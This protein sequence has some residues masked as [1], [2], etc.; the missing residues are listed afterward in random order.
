M[1]LE[2]NG[3]RRALCGTCTV[4]SRVA[5]GYPAE[6]PDP[7]MQVSLEAALRVCDA[8]ATPCLEEIEA[9]R[10]AGMRWRNDRAAAKA[11][12]CMREDRILGASML[13]PYVIKSWFAQDADTDECARVGCHN[14]HGRGNA[15]A[16]GL[17]RFCYNVRGCMLPGNACVVVW[18]MVTISGLLDPLAACTSVTWIIFCRGWVLILHV[19]LRRM[20]ERL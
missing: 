15:S 10:G 3:T 9:A 14:K 20:P 13:F 4:E 1:L 8:D 11:L 19:L 2:N 17:C 7:A 16:P 12:L 6:L 5:R 18:L